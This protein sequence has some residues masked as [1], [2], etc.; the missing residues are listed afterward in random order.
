MIDILGVILL[1]PLYISYKIAIGL[2]WSAVNLQMSFLSH[3]F[4]Y[5]FKPSFKQTLLRIFLSYIIS[6]LGRF[7]SPFYV[8]T[9][10]WLEMSIFLIIILAPNLILFTKWFNKLHKF[11]FLACPVKTFKIRIP[12]IIKWIAPQSLL[13]N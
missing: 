10:G 8:G 7:T 5:H 3:S 4:N 11:F 12:R 1:K 13:L 6:F 9:Y 2:Q